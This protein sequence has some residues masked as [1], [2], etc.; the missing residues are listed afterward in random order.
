MPQF[1]LFQTW[2]TAY[3]A[4]NIAKI[5]NVYTMINVH[6]INDVHTAERKSDLAY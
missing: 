3:K 1:D 4:I 5:I 2:R 6:I